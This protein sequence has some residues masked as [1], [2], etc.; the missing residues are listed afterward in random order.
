[1]AVLAHVAIFRTFKRYQVGGLLRPAIGEDLYWTAM[2][3]DDVVLTDLGKF[4][5]TL[6][7]RDR[8]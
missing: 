7:T 2:R 5:H 8:I 1:M 3:S 6:V 4:Y